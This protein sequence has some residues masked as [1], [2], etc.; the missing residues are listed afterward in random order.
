MNLKDAYL[1]MDNY[2]TPKVI[3]EVN[4]QYIKIVK[5]KG[6]ES[7]TSMLVFTHI[8]LFVIAIFMRAAVFF[9]LNLVS[10]FFL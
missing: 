3:G 8:K 10:M 1:S 5:I 7:L 9:A 2:F 4:D 6:Q